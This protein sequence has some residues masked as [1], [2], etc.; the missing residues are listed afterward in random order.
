MAEI[1]LAALDGQCLDRRIGDQQT[2]AKEIAAWEHKR[3]AAHISIKWHF[4]TD[5]ARIKLR[6][7]YPIIII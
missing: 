3:N 4:T 6:H 5:D 1:E 2:L 7:L